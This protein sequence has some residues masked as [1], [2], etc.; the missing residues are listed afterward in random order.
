MGFNKPK[1]KCWTSLILLL[2]ISCAPTS[3][4]IKIS[5]DGGYSNV[6]VKISDSLDMHK[7][8]AIISGLKVK[9]QNSA[10]NLQIF[11]E[12][13]K[14]VLWCVFRRPVAKIFK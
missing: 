10:K 4:E 9:F 5:E 8:G 12:D 7:C 11:N 1:L 3:G 2:L 14:L 13:S 6:I